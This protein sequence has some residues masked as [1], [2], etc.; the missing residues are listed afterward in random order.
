MKVYVI[1]KNEIDYECVYS[2]ILRVYV[3][4]ARAVEYHGLLNAV[5][6]NKRVKYEIE[7]YEVSE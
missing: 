5:N 7:Y 1:V 2:Q 4:V 3:N 6:N